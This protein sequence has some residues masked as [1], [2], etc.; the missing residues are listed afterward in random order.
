MIHSRINH[1]V[2]GKSANLYGRPP[3][4]QTTRPSPPSK[5]PG[6]S[7]REEVALCSK[8][9]ELLADV[10]FIGRTRPVEPRNQTCVGLVTVPPV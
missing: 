9:L 2:T 7:R 6:S 5:L 3:T 4:E 1:S 10:P 8:T